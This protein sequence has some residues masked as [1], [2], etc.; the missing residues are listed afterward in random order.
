MTPDKILLHKKSRELELT[1]G[2]QAYR[3]DAEY[4]RVHSPSAEVRGHQGS[5]GVLPYGKRNVA[6]DTIEAA[7][8]YALKIIFNDGHDSGIYT[9]DYLHDL[10]VN[11]EAHWQK[12]LDDL[13]QQGKSRDPDTQVVR[14]M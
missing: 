8:N 1:Y 10:C 13:D 6:I 12:Y 7:G 4:L 14:L 9:W 3:L 5:G 2:D 11:K